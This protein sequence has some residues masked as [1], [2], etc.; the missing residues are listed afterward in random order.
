MCCS[1]ARSS[2]TPGLPPATNAKHPVHRYHR[3]HVT[4]RKNHKN[5]V[6]RK[7]WQ[8]R[9]SDTNAVRQCRE[10]GEGHGRVGVR[11]Q[12]RERPAVRVFAEPTDATAPLVGRTSN[13]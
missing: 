7:G 4:P 3:M 2:A 12:G 11:E 8:E 1:A 13:E 9:T 10:R 5:V 6:Y